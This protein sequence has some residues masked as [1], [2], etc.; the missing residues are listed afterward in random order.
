MTPPNNRPELSPLGSVI[1]NATGLTPALG[2]VDND[3]LPEIVTT[4]VGGNPV[5]FEHD[6]AKKWISASSWPEVYSGAIA[7]ADADNDGDVD[8]DENNDHNENNYN[9]NDNS[10]DD[11][12]DD[13]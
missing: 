13:E 5:V 7:L 11:N 3:G 6:G 8:N 4:V 9:N 12:S 2:D 1:C 10:N